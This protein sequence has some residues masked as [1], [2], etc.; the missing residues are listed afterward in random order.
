MMREPR[1][2]PKVALGR[3]PTPCYRL[4]AVS[5]RY[6]RRIFIK[7]DDLCG[8]SLGGNKIRKLE[9]LL[10]DAKAKGCDTVFTTGS[11]QSNHA[12]LT[13]ASA[14]R[15]GMRCILF[16]K[17]PAPADR[18]GNL[19][20]DDLFGA[21][22][23]FMDTNHYA[24]IYDAMLAE[25]EKLTA[26]G[27][28]C[29]AIPAGGSTPLGSL[30]YVECADEIARQCPNVEHIVCA[31]GTGG[32]TAGLML[33]VKMYLPGVRVTGIPVYPGA[34]EDIVPQL[35]HDAAE[36]LDQPFALEP[37]DLRLAPHIG[38]GFGIPNPADTPLITE[39]A[40]MEGIL[41]DPVYTGKA[42]AGMLELLRKGHFNGNGPIV[43]VHTGG[44]ST[45]FAADTL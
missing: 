14:A 15:L 28:K 22:I 40:R 1:D 18:R 29:F 19:F 6:A 26:E 16:L 2:L 43:F 8:V 21:E 17:G 38:E 45:L 9:F 11:P 27:H 7:R 32:T 20:L 39:L 36:L 31:A 25:D 44:I 24:E 41:L 10:A 23:R 5:A 30:G 3:F 34:L 33:G 35:A 37:G 4:E 13:A 42:W 12:M